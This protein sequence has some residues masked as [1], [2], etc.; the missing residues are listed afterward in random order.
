[1]CR[2]IRRREFLRRSSGAALSTS[3]ALAGRNVLL[4][5]IDPQGNAGSGIGVAGDAQVGF[6]M[7]EVNALVGTNQLPDAL[8]ERGGLGH[9]P[10]QTQLPMG[11][12]LGEERIDQ[13]FQLG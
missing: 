8:T 13:L 1:M 3:L 9:H 10:R 2:T 7:L 4:V 5:D 11:V 6:K 12:G